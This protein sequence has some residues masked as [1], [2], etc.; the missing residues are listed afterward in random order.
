VNVKS[1]LTL[2]VAQLVE[3]V[4]AGGYCVGCG[5]CASI[6]GSK[7][8]VEMNDYGM[9]TASVVDGENL[10]QRVVCP[11]G[12]DSP[13]E[14]QIGE[15]LFSRS[16]QYTDGLGYAVACYAGHVSD[17]SVR[18]KGSSGGMGTWIIL[19]LL[20]QRK[21]DGVIH[22]G[23]SDD[24]D[25][26]PFTYKISTTEE[27]VIQRAKSRYYP[28]EM[29]QVI[30]ELRGLKGRF[31]FVGLP[32]FVKALRLVAATDEDIKN[33]IAYT[34]A[35]FC[36][37]LKSKHFADFF[38][39]QM[40]IEPGSLEGIN[41]RTKLPSR[42]ASNY[43]ISVSSKR[44]MQ[45]KAND[46]YYGSNWG[47]GF[48]KYKA[49]DYC[50]DVVGETAD[51]SV[52]D[53]WLPEYVNDSGGTNV[54]VVRKP[55]LAMMVD[56]AISAGDLVMKRVSPSRV[57]KSQEAGLRHRRTGL[58]FRLYQRDRSATWRPT[59]RVQA[60]V[61]NI[62][63]RQ[64]E[65]FALRER[66]AEE[67]HLAFYDARTRGSIAVFQDRMEPLVRKYDA[68]Y[69]PHGIAKL[70]NKVRIYLARAKRAMLRILTL[71]N[72]RNR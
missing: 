42:P 10:D 54:V 33:R 16:A 28:I 47:Y 3:T 53:A 35:L 19:E 24:A 55:E 7:M 58:A 32:C 27:E 71:L 12:A 40:G 52:G 65:I 26:L 8:R 51:I 46:E 18:S 6:Q 62:S 21:I 36:G 9:F 31:A 17:E 29:S 72:H 61:S 38:A 30:G 41:F 2:P 25:G 44:N 23:G 4:I 50:D 64:K 15:E 67:S 45:C 43:G 20:R 57:V 34:V 37:H 60:G 68:L 56:S 14:D 63:A 48:F 49:C 39:W 5:A 13:N 66:L 70:T 59:K 22:V 1:A 11:F 69:M